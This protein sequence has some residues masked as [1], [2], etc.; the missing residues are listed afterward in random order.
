MPASAASQDGSQNRT[1]AGV[2]L[3]RISATLVRV[4]G[5]FS[6]REPRGYLAHHPKIPNR[7]S[8]ARPRP[9]RPRGTT[10]H[11]KS[12]T[13]HAQQ[14]C[15]APR[16]SLP[17]RRSRGQQCP[18]GRTGLFACDHCRRPLEPWLSRGMPSPPPVQIWLFTI[19][20]PRKSRSRAWK[21]RTPSPDRDPT[22]AASAATDTC[23]G[24]LCHE[25]CADTRS[26]RHLLVTGAP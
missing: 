4:S 17:I 6:L 24:T 2:L 8:P 25:G 1:D 5:V 3:A 10:R 16:Q 20:R 18:A 22:K 12:G 13:H 26:D 11:E 15:G 23:I 21:D 9:E 7:L 19:A 14:I